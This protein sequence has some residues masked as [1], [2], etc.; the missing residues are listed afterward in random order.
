MQWS[1]FLCPTSVLS[2]VLYSISNLSQLRAAQ[3]YNKKLDHF[4]HIATIFL[5]QQENHLAIEMLR[6]LCQTL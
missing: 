4:I 6:D 2:N 5:I 1:V 3:H